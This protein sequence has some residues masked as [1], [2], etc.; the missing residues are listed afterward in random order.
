MIRQLL[1]KWF[2][3]DPPHCETCEVLR[4]Q[5]EKSERERVDLL[6]RLINKEEKPEPPV[7]MGDMQPVKPQYIP[8]RI[9]QQMLEAEDRRRAEILKN[10]EKEIDDLEKELKIGG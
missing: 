7:E 1:Y 8:W 3:L 4:I 6:H 5:L 10:R 2:R 9:K